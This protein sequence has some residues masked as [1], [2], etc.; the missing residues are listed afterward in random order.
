LRQSDAFNPV[1]GAIYR[2]LVAHRTIRP[3][4][5]PRPATVRAS[6]RYQRRVS[7]AEFVARV[8]RHSPST[9]VP[10]VA[11]V[12]AANPDV[13]DWMGKGIPPWVLAEIARVS[14]LRGT[15]F[16][17]EP[18]TIADLND[19]ANAFLNLDDRDLRRHKPGSVGDFLLRLGAQ[20]LT[21]QQQTFHDISR[22]AAVF[23]HAADPK[24]PPKI[25]SGD[26]PEQLFGCS[27]VEYLNLAFLLYVGALRNGGIFD[28]AWIAAPQFAEIRQS[29]SS[30]L[31]RA[32]FHS[33]FVADKARLRA[34][35]DEVEAAV[36]RPELDYRRFGHNPLSKFPVVSGLSD[37]WFMPVPQLLLRKASPIGIFYAGIKKFG[38]AFANDLGPLFEAYVGDQ[39]RLLDPG[40]LGEIE[41]TEDKNT[42]L[43]VDFIVPLEQCV[44][45]IDAKSTR[46]TEEIRAGAPNA[47]DKLAGLLNKGVKQLSNTARL[48]T[49][50]HPAFAH[51]P[52]DRP[53]IGLLVTMEPFHTVNTPFVSGALDGCTIPY[54]VASSEEIEALVRLGADDIGQR[55]L[56]HMTDPER[57]G[58]SVKTLVENRELGRNKLLD[59]AWDSI[60]WPGVDD[61]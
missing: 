12:G 30:E 5:S 18:A 53:I 43:S 21:W 16:N 32:V 54:R 48:I 27:L 13:S 24:R 46:P 31:M 2:A 20:Q 51:I 35:Q 56:E 42:K 33:Q 52:A 6:V 10:L 7:E 36:G 29:I 50:R 41:Y 1:G 23:Q 38:S 57:E 26:W 22:A 9:L 45:L 47:G 60:K 4:Q 15:E 11:A 28:P 14:L 55:L 49:E 58:H 3:G 44:L 8:R 19:C 37:L 39:L 61:V 34:D 40:V 17:R 59:E 25:I